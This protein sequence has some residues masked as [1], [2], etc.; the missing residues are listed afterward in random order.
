MNYV[1]FGFVGNPRRLEFLGNFQVVWLCPKLVCEGLELAPRAIPSE[2]VLEHLLTKVL[3]GLG[4][5]F[6]V[7]GAFVASHLSN[8]D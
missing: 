2:R 6:V 3:G 4:E 7:V 8:G 5:T 1:T